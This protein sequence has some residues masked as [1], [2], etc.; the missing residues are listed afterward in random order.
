[1]SCPV[2]TGIRTKMENLGDT[3]KFYQ[4]GKIKIR[5]ASELQ[6]TAPCLT[7]KMIVLTRFTHVNS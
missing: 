1:M 5:Q 4:N 7:L 3:G 2:D 6:T